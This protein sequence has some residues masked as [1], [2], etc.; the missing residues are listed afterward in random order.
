MLLIEHDIVVFVWSQRKLLLYLE[1]LRINEESRR[2]HFKAMPR[3]G[4]EL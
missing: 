4:N 2:G 3:R 1:M